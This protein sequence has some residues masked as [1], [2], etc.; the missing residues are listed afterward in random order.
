MSLFSRE[1]NSEAITAKRYEKI[2]SITISSSGVAVRYRRTLA[3]PDGT[4][5][6]LGEFTVN[7]PLD[8]VTDEITSVIGT[9]TDLAEKWRQENETAAAE[10]AAT[11]AAHQ[12]QLAD[13][14][15]KLTAS[16]PAGDTD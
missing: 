16:A 4:E 3:L 9:L 2:T 11:E 13:L 12:A 8:Q 10:A 5:T 15:A 7:R 14:R 6:S 1:T